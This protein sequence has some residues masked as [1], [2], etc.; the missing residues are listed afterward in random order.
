MRRVILTTTGTSLL[1]SW[2]KR[3]PGRKYDPEQLARA[4]AEGELNSAEAASLAKLE[5]DPVYDYV[6]LFASD[7]SEGTVCMEAL[8]R[9]LAE[10]GQM[11]VDPVTIKG[12]NKNYHDFQTRGLPNLFGKLTETVQRHA[13]AKVIIN[14]TGGF[15][16]QTSYAT[17]FGIMSGLEV[18]YMHEDFS[19]LLV[20]PPM[21]VGCDTPYILQ[22]KEVFAEITRAAS[23]KE[24]RQLIDNL[25]T[26][27]RGFFMK[28]GERYVYSPIGTFFMSQMEKESRARSYTVRTNKNHTSL[29]GD[30]IQ[31][32]ARIK[33]AEV[34]DLFRKIFDT[35]PYVTAVFLD[36]M[37][38]KNTLGELYMEYVETQNQ[39]LRYL[40]HTPQGSEYIKIEVLPGMEKEALRLLGKRIYA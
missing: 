26:Q 24:A 12:L 30:G 29:W 7:T 34:R 17:F 40:M 38:P 32:L 13:G 25:P 21:P 14:A 10:K 9:Y 23:K 1:T 16:A 5:L 18:V 35:V 31:E 15:K 39:A 8:S 3:N 36:E 19:S 22:H 27:L 20:F 37:V 28:D 11:Y 2:E 6:Y 4:L 33:D